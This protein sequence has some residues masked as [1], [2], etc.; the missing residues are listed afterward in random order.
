MHYEIIERDGAVLDV[1][2]DEASGTRLTVSRLGAEPTS[3]QRRTSAGEWRGFLHRDGLITLPLTGWGNHATVMGYYLHRLKGGR[4]IYRGQEIKDGNHG[5]I[6]RK[7]FGAPRVTADALVYRIA[8]GDFTK[9]EYPCDVTLEITYQLQGDGG[10]R[11]EFRFENREPSL[12]AHVSFGLHPGFMI[13]SLADCRVELPA[14]DYRHFLAPGDFLSGETRPIHHAGGEVPFP[15][16]TLPGSYLIE[17]PTT[18][19]R[20]CALVDPAGGRRVTVDLSECPFL[21]LWSDGRGNFVCIEPCWGLPDHHEQRAF[22]DKLGIQKIGPGQGLQRG[23]TV[24][25]ECT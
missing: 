2:T 10:W 9:E 13:G 18:G 6:R 11:T 5:L 7:T 19:E 12:D 20:W 14:G 17:V 8:P 22:E 23:F 3:L 15:K 4:T 25:T 24:R 1:L 21:T 16:D